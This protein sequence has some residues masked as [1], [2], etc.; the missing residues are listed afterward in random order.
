ME[1]NVDITY[2][3]ER[4]KQIATLAHEGQKRNSGSPYIEHPIRVASKV[5]DRLKPIALLHDVVEDTLIT[6]KDL[7]DLKFPSYI[8]DAVDLLTHKKGDTNVT[9]WNKIMTNPDAINVKLRDIED[10]LASIPSVYARSKYAKAL[11]SL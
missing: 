6:L 10:N 1:E 11:D 8:L 9:Y 2:W 3:I 7:E 5:E 4:A